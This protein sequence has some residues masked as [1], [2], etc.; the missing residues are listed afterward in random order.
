MLPDVLKTRFEKPPAKSGNSLVAASHPSGRIDIF[1]MEC[2]SPAATK[3]VTMLAEQ[4]AYA[5]FPPIII[6]LRPERRM[7]WTHER[8]LVRQRKREADLRAAL[9][10]D[11]CRRARRR[12]PIRR[13]ARGW[14]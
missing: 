2:S 8:E 6:P 3:I 13:P 11:T 14:A 10:R 9:A 12:D 4:V 5:D 7:I 1:A